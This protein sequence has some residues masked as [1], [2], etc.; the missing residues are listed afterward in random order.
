VTGVNGLTVST[1][2][3]DDPNGNQ[4]S[5]LGRTTVW[6]SYN[7]LAS[8]TEGSSTISSLDNPEHQRFLQVT[9]QHKR[10]PMI[11]FVFETAAFARQYQIGV[12]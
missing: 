1:T 10:L 11:G 6:T 7:K 3:R 9:A 5:V 2:F 12:S 8:I 4:I